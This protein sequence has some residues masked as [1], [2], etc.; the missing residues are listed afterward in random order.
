M[1]Q[2]SY[3]A[4]EHQ[5]AAWLRESRMGDG[6]GVSSSALRRVRRLTSSAAKVAA[7]PRG[8]S[9]RTW[10]SRRCFQSTRYPSSRPGR[11]SG[12]GWGAL[13]FHRTSE[14][15]AL[16][17]GRVTLFNQAGMVR[18]Q[19]VALPRHVLAGRQRD[20]EPCCLAL[21]VRGLRRP[22]PKAVAFGLQHAALLLQHAHSAD[23][24]RSLS[25]I[26]LCSPRNASRSACRRRTGGI[27]CRR[28]NNTLKLA[29][30]LAV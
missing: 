14:P 11:A 4:A 28:R 22:F 12:L 19:A 1:V 8:V 13:L 25:C 9:S 3:R 27:Q 24:A 2:V 6:V 7:G 5:A 30:S 23:A 18:S 26:E 15:V 17:H 29:S 16:R 21:V 20:P 10:L